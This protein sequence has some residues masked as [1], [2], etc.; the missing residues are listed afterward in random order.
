MKKLT[1]LLAFITLLLSLPI[2]SS[3]QTL[4][5]PETTRRLNVGERA[6][7]SV[8]GAAEDET[9]SWS[10]SAPSI[11]AVNR[12]GM[13]MGR[14]AGRAAITATVGTVRITRTITVRATS[15]S[16][17]TVR[18]PA[19]VNPTTLL[20]AYAPVFGYVGA[21]AYHHHWNQPSQ[22][23]GETLGFIKK[24]YNSLTA[25]NEMKP[26]F[27][28]N[29]STIA[30]SEARNRGY[31]IPA[32]WN[33]N[34]PVPTINAERINNYLKIAQDNGLKIRFHTL[35][36]YSQT[37]SWFF[38]E[39][40]NNNGA[41]VS[42]REMDRRLEFYVKSVINIVHDG[43]YS[44]VVY[45]WDVVNEHITNKG[46]GGW[47][48]IYGDD[49]NNIFVK[50]AFRF[51][52]EQLAALDKRGNAGLFYN[53]FNTYENAAAIV[54][55]INYINSGAPGGVKYCDG[56]G[57]QMHLD[58]AYPAIATIGRTIDTFTNAGFEIQITELDVTLN[59][60]SWAPARTVQQQEQ[61]WGDLFTMLVQKQK[62]GANITSVTF[63]GLGD[64]V[65][66]RSRHTPLLF[67]DINRPKPAFDAVMNAAR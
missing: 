46:K 63:W 35:I 2:V 21:A 53:D 47:G 28:L 42:Q 55:L 62:G 32:G 45:A 59:F 48:Q 65:S 23:Q 27:L 39:N 52:H 10:S 5:I 11:V 40:Y 16:P 50:N 17:E 12:R 57:M 44:D 58:A 9:V 49:A 51:A 67:T 15:D 31:V 7:L 33:N 38:R 4:R 20:E 25:E 41:F 61:Y 54:S 60:H 56:V 13:I 43:L 6:S 24:H 3:A 1:L 29:S 34:T 19:S 22:L 14:K 26:D 64:S 37:P 36:W 18:P 30:A 66:W 8:V